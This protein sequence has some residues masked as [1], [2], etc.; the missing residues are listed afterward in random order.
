MVVRIAICWIVFVGAVAATNAAAGAK[1]K[2]LVSPI[3]MP[4]DQSVVLRRVAD[5]GARNDG[6]RLTTTWPTP[7]INQ[8]D[9]IVNTIDVYNAVAGQKVRI[10]NSNHGASYFT[11]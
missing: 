5:G 6:V 11:T 9:T 8:G 10:Q 2:T 1:A 7:L 4:Q 3:S